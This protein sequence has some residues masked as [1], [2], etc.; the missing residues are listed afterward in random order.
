MFEF[1]RELRSKVDDK[2]F[3]EILEMAEHD[4][5]FNRIG[6]GKKTS[7][8]DFITICES[9]EFLLTRCEVMEAW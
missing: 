9:C 3:K 7:A 2:T 1:L 8:K 6:F 4:I 5:K